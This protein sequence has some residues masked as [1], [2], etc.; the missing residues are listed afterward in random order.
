MPLDSDMLGRPTT[1]EFLW[2]AAKIGRDFRNDGLLRRIVLGHFRKSALLLERGS[3]E[4]AFG[5]T[6]ARPTPASL[7]R[8]LALPLLRARG[9]MRDWID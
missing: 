6:S 7:T 3:I 8:H 9:Q 2:V 1:G 5:P 4:R